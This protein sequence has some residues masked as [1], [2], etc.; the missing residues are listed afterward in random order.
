DEIDGRRPRPRPGPYRDD[1]GPVGRGVAVGPVVAG[2]FQQGVGIAEARGE[3]PDLLPDGHHPLVA[4]GRE[5]ERVNPRP[6]EGAGE[7]RWGWKRL[8]REQV[9]TAL[10]ESR[11]S[12]D[13]HPVRA[14]GLRPLERDGAADS[15]E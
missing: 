2:L 6:G 12:D 5:G 8:E 4:A 1:P 10:R 9:V 13:E 7:R 14:V 11:V 15:H 3:A